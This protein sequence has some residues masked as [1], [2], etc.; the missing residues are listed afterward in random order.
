MKDWQFTLL[1]LVWYGVV[2]LL[3][4]GVLLFFWIFFFLTPNIPPLWQQ[5]IGCLLF[6]FGLLIKIPADSY[7]GIAICTFLNTLV[8][9]TLVLFIKERVFYKRDRDQVSVQD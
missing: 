4:C 3:I 7:G 5:V 1:K 8:W 6:P 9:A 2:Y